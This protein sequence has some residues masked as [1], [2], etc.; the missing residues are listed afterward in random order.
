MGLT[1]V[2]HA[3]LEC[4]NERRWNDLGEFVNA[5]LTYNE[6]PMTLDDYRALLQADAEAIPDLRYVPDLVIADGDVV[7]CRLYFDCSPQRPFLGVDT[8]GAA[9]SFAEHVFYRF[10]SGKIARVWSLIDTQAIAAQARN[11]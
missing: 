11:P 7:G 1:D 10:A 3:Y 2:Y 8:G 5:E 9:I 6:R 4:L